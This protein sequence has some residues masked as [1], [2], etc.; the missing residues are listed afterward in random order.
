MWQLPIADFPVCWQTTCQSSRSKEKDGFTQLVTE[1]YKSFNARGLLLSAA[2]SSLT[3]VIDAAYDVPKSAQNL[4]W[5]S[6]MEYD[7]HGSWDSRTG[8]NAPLYFHPGDQSKTLN[9]N[10]TTHYWMSKGAPSTKLVMG[11][12]SYGQSFTL[13]NAQQNGLNAPTTGP[14]KGGPL[15]QSD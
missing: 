3:Y 5:I 7:Y 10:F 11:V 9:S 12:P 4:D 1:L 14:G 15:T 2:V 8:H 6:I 13:K